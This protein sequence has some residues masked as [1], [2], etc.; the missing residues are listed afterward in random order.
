MRIYSM[1]ATFGKLENQTLTLQP[2]LNIISAP[3]EWGKT[4]WCTFLATMLYGLDTREKTTKTNLA[5]KERYAPW[6]GS[7]MS[8]RMDINWNGRDITI[9]RW[10]KGRT[11]MGEFRAY[12]TD[13]GLPVTELTGANC[14]ETLLGVEKSVFL[15]AGFL[16][17][18]DLPV[19]TDD[20]LRR[21]LN[22]LVTTGDES[23]ASDA[24]AQKLK[25]LKN[26][27]RSNKSN[28][29]IPQA[30]EQRQ[31]LESKL[32]E[33]R[34][35]QIQ[36]KKLEEQRQQVTGQISDLNNHLAAL[37]YIAAQDHIRRVEQ[38]HMAAETAAEEMAKLEDVCATLPSRDEALRQLQHHAQLQQAQ[39]ALL[40]EMTSL[41]PEPTQPP[42]PARYQALTP[43]QA[44]A[45]AQKDTADHAALEAAKKGSGL[46]WLI[47]G[48]GAVLMLL[49][50]LLIGGGMWIASGILIALGGAGVLAYQNL[51]T[52]KIQSQLDAIL[53]RYYDI[54][55]QRWIEDAEFYAETQR[56]YK[57]A[58]GNA[59]SLRRDLRRQIED[60]EAAITELIGHGSSQDF[61]LS[62][63]EILATHDAL[64]D[65]RRAHQH[66]AAHADTLRT[67][68]KPAAKP[69]RPDTLSLTEAQT[70]AMLRQLDFEQKQLQLRLG[71]YQGR[72]EALGS[73][74]HLQRELDAVLARLEKLNLT[75]RALELAQTTLADATAQLQRRFAP[76]I[77]A[78]AKVFFAA[79]TDGR[80]DRL[81]LQQ[82]LS[83][84][85]AADQDNTIRSAQW[86]SDGTIDQLYLALRLA[87]AAELTPSAPLILD[88][89]LVR[90]D[91]QRH[92]AAMGILQEQ[93]KSK[94][95]I[96]FTCQSREQNYK[97]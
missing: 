72:I 30:E 92:A 14:G 64:A 17:L 87:V 1:T 24:L 3:N 33:L 95:I 8:G 60:N 51:R 23:D 21:R 77:T 65:A 12:E 4:T 19:T 80:Y 7:P 93:A 5:V 96:L 20:S 71:Q 32:T 97:L 69:E 34:T 48:I 90:F 53:S 36:L 70:D 9:E 13:S 44:L 79:L 78:Q 55:P 84:E 18:S 38:A 6:S 26:K 22:A 88:D 46:P 68:A 29:L 50:A 57:V 86:R 11:P 47:F 43:E 39:S 27:C 41:P 66:A 25:D 81:Q 40:L 61:L 35:L 83:V 74:A 37:Q 2:E 82:D 49:L 91:D 94:Q 59:L 85:T 31:E 76:R 52:G 89:A 54:P 62:R 28:G 75:Y 16:R 63:N 56:Q 10:T 15:R 42:V 45:Q 58:L 67:L 73:E